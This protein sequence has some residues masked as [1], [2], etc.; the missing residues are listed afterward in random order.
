M[1]DIGLVSKFFEKRGYKVLK[2]AHKNANGP[3]LTIVNDYCAYRIE[4][5]TA[6]KIKSGSI[7]VP[8]ISEPR[9]SDDFVVVLYCKEIVLIESMR[10]YLRLCASDGTRSITLFANMLNSSLG[11]AR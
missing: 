10:D 11:V 4:I 2:A 6:R 9:K 5:K 8:P 3:D 1:D 7:Q